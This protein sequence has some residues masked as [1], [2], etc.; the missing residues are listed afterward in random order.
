[1]WTH[2][3]RDRLDRR[4]FLIGTPE[5]S[6]LGKS[7]TPCPQVPAQGVHMN[8]MADTPPSNLTKRAIGRQGGEVAVS[9]GGV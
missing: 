1:M 2:P 7:D 5:L 6:P 4:L 9:S 8:L 3:V